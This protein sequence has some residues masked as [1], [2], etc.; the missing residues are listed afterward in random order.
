VPGVT[1]PTV[2][3]ACKDGRALDNPR[4]AHL[5]TRGGRAT[6]L[7]SS[8]G[9]LYR[10]HWNTPFILS[11]HD[12]NI[13]YLG[14]NRLFKSYDRGDTWVSSADLTKQVDRCKV[15]VMGVRGDED[16]LAENDGIEYYSTIVS[17]A[18]SRVMPG[19]VWAGTDD[20]NL[21]VS[22]DG[23]LT[24]IEVGRNLPASHFAAGMAYIA[25]DGHNS[26]D[27]KPYVF[28][29]RDYGATFQSITNDLPAYGNVRV[30]REDP[31][32]KDLL[33]V[34]TEFGL[35]ASTDGGVHWKKFMNDFPT[36]RVDD[37]LIHPREGDLIVATHGRSLLIA[38]DITALQ[39]F[40]PAVAAQDAFLFEPRTAVAWVTDLTANPYLGGARNFAADNAPAGAAISYYLKAA[41]DDVKIAV[42]DASGRMVGTMTGPRTAGI[43]KLAWSALKSGERATAPRVEAGVYQV[44][45]ATGGKT[46]VR[47][48]TILEDKWFKAR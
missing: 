35:Y 37:I 10:F 47:T 14:G 17:V 39:R 8:A 13:V 40:T 15:V 21:Q 48:L 33:F 36:V 5:G 46:L 25:V 9:D 43:H 30:I 42:T 4:L 23:G 41:A 22:R 27:M 24:F 29:T 31:K 12:P 16:M 2:P 20:G 3:V 28:V 45:L 38:D 7:N 6:V 1:I 18:E 19:V 44:S 34:G 11:P 32:N 26:D